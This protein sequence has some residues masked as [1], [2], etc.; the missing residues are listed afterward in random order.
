MHSNKK[1]KAG[2]LISFLIM[3]LIEELW[4]DKGNLLLGWASKW[5]YKLRFRTVYANLGW[6]PYL[7]FSISIWVCVNHSVPGKMLPSHPT[8]SHPVSRTARCVL[9]C[10]TCPPLRTTTSAP[11]PL[12][13]RVAMRLS[14][15]INGA[16]NTQD[17]QMMINYVSLLMR[18]ITIAVNLY[19]SLKHQFK[20][21]HDGVPLQTFWLCTGQLLSGSWEEWCHRAQFPREVH[22]QSTYKHFACHVVMVKF[23]RKIIT[24]HTTPTDVKAATM[25]IRVGIMSNFPACWDSHT[26][27]RIEVRWSTLNQFKSLITTHPVHSCKHCTVRQWMA[28]VTL[29]ILYMFRWYTAYVLRRRH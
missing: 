12:S 22:M 27:L 11:Q 5:P 26:Q 1:S 6:I 4:L 23:L 28:A 25:L 19:I 21:Q 24:V 7:Y 13:P 18:Y 14:Q 8:A 20:I 2:A 15:E 17:N 29:W 16:S 10:D 3:C 9:W